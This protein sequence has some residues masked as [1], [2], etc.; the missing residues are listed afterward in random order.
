M[1]SPAAD[2]RR[3]YLACRAIFAGNNAL[4][5]KQK[6]ILEVL[7]QHANVS[8]K[9]LIKDFGEEKVLEILKSLL[10]AQIFQS[11]LK[12]KIEFPELF[13]T[14]LVRDVQRAASEIDATRSADEALDEILSM[15]DR[16]DLDRD[17]VEDDEFP[18]VADVVAS[19]YHLPRLRLGKNCLHM[20]RLYPWRMIMNGYS[21][22]K[23]GLECF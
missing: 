19:E 6:K 14:S 1:P 3:V 13:V 12:A 10:E 9:P 16:D 17:Q 18:A 20:S 21:S 7:R 15:D 2:N 5:R 11:E 23:L 4:L 8:L 22:K